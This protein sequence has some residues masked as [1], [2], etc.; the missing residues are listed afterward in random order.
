[1]IDVASLRPYPLAVIPER[2]ISVRLTFA[3]EKLRLSILDLILSCIERC[4]HFFGIIHTVE[5]RITVTRKPCS[6]YACFKWSDYVSITGMSV[7]GWIAV[8]FEYVW[9]ISAC[10]V[11]F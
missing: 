1:M 9:P 3:P 8:E 6:C 2:G 7:F 4:P 10:F 5:R 11:G